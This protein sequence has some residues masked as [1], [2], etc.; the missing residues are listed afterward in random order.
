MNN[1]KEIE[2]KKNLIKAFG[3]NELLKYRIFS[4]AYQ[5]YIHYILHISQINI[6]FKIQLFADETWEILECL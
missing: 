6:A 5:L 3:F 4:Q 2:R 1:K